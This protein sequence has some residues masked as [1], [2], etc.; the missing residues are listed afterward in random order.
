MGYF[1]KVKDSKLKY[2]STH[3]QSLLQVELWNDATITS[4]LSTI[5]RHLI[6]QTVIVLSAHPRLLLS[7]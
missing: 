5:V 4:G 3:A 7:T 1:G 6:S 2:C